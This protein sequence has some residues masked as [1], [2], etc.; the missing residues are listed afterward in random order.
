MLTDQH[1]GT[2]TAP[3]PKLVSVVIPAYNEAAGIEGT[4][5]EVGSTLQ[6]LG[7]P[8]EIIIVDDGSDD[9]T[10]AIVN[11]LNLSDSR[12][13]GL[14]FSR[15]FGKEAALLAGLESA[16]GD[17]VVTM[18][19]D[20]QHPPALIPVMLERWRAG[21]MVVHGV[22]HKREHDGVVVRKLSD[23]FNTVFSMSGGFDMR[24]GSD[25]KLLGRTAVDVVV[26]KLPE[27]RRFYRGLAAW[28]GFTQDSVPFD[29]DA[30]ASGGGKWSLAGLLELATTAI[31]SFTS[32]PLRIVTILGAV[33]LV[34]GIILAADTV[35]SWFEGQA[36]SGFATII[37]TL[38]LL[39][40]FIMIS[41]GII[42]E[43]IA[44][45]Y[46]E[47]KERPAYLVESRCGF[48]SGG[49]RAGE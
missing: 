24:N 30:R 16:R 49:D 14:R 1:G 32:A 45:I 41:L 2:Q 3:E 26:R 6:S 13:R 39:G 18:D 17:V 35:W 27:R 42:G 34:F 21:A 47:I 19:A 46:D 5:E 23:L 11:R 12:L 22:K 37:I 25:F 38:L 36:V 7:L 29:V 48:E 43:Y 31:I 40:S 20:L 28:V 10:F 4:L 8:Y 9:A 33:T 15:R 44:K